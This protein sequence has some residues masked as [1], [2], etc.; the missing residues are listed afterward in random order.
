MRA[1]IYSLLFF[2][3]LALAGCSNGGGSGSD[4]APAPTAAHPLGWLQQHGAEALKSPNFQSCVLCHG[5][6]L[7]GLSNVPSCYSASYNGQACHP[8]G[9][10]APHPLDGTFLNPANHG[11]VAKRDLT[12]CQDCHGQAGGPG[13][14]PR[15]NRGIQAAGNQGCEGCHGTSLAHPAEWAGPNATFHYSAGNIQQSCTLCHGA[16]LN[17]AGGVGPS[18]LGCHDSVSAFTLDCTFCHGY[19]PDGTA[20]LDVPSGVAHGGVAAIGSHD[21]CVVCHGVKE[22][23]GGYFS[24]DTDYALFNK[25]TGAQGYHWDGRINMNGETAYNETNFG[26]DAALCH[27]N[28][29]GHRLSDSG[30]PVELGNY[31]S[32]A[33]AIPHPIPFTDSAQHG[34]AAKGLTAAF[35]QG[36]LDCQPCHGQAGVAGSNPRFNVGIAAAGGQG[37]EGCHGLNLAHP[38]SWYDRVVTHSDVNGLTMCALC[39]GAALDGGVGPA[40]TSCHTVDPVANPTGCVSCHNTPPDGAVPAGNIRPNRDGRH[41]IGDH[42]VA[43]AT[44]HEGAGAGTPGHFDQADPADVAIQATFGGTYNPLTGNCSNVSCHGA[45]PNTEGPWYP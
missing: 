37:C 28:D 15:F 24:A 25:L 4:T 42:Q 3:I 23:A 8:G 1:S 43:C 7:R 10:G 21:V 29:A 33:G 45:L 40:C 16:T 20:D 22:N 38:L 35:P 44:C 6:D 12:A 14:N 27:G 17:G 5:A 11:P 41:S 31:G 9:P 36:M 18:C 39:H 2:A 13:S 32:G 30:L 19:P 34:P 26:C